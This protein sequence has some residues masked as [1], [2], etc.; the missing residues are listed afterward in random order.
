MNRSVRRCCVEWCDV[1]CYFYLLCLGGILS[2]YLFFLFKQKTAYEMRIS[3]WSSDVCSSDLPRF[4][5]RVFKDRRLENVLER[6]DHKRV[7]VLLIGAGDA[8]ELFIR[9][10]GRDRNAPFRVVG[11]VD[12][13]GTRIGRSIHGVPVLGGLE[14]VEHIIPVR[15]PG[16]PQRLILTLERMAGDRKNTRLNSRH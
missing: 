2:G 8:A 9:H 16:R 15:A 7:P 13:K 10:Q 3:D 12:D 1:L 11:V 14:E 5:Y 6:A 4:V